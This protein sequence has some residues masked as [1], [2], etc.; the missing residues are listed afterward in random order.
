MPTFLEV[1]RNFYAGALLGLVLV[2]LLGNS[3]P[4]VILCLVLGV[5]LGWQLEEW[6]DR[7]ARRRK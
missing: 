4:V 7:R 3:L 6:D 5:V 1:M 2:L